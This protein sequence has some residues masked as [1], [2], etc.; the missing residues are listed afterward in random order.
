[1]RRRS[2]M[3]LL[4]VANRDPAALPGR[5]GHPPLG[6]LPRAILAFEVRQPGCAVAEQVALDPHPV[7]QREVE[8]VER[9]AALVLHVPKER[10][11]WQP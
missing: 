4:L 8:V 2:R 11:G 6:G 1:M 7:E 10:L 5:P 9:R 3:A